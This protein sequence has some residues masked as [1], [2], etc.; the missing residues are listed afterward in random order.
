M[1]AQ[2]SVSRRVLSQAAAEIYQTR[3][4]E[5]KRLILAKLLIRT[6]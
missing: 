2:T 3:T 6:K 4:I 1:C 5:Q